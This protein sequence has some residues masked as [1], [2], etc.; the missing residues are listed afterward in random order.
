VTGYAF[1]IGNSLVSW[2][3]TLQPIVAL[4]TIEGEYMA[5]AEA[6]KEEIWLKGLISDL[7]FSQDKVIIFCDSLSAICFAKDQVH[8]ERTKHIDV[9]YHFIC[10]EK[11]IEVQRVDTRENPD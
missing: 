2:K 10:I 11:R 1:T 4:S 7:G 8:H 9:R 3:A 6:M 5:L